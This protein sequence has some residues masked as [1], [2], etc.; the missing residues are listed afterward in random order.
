MWLPTRYRAPAV[1]YLVQHCD[2]RDA[3]TSQL[4]GFTAEREAEACLKQLT[5]EG[6]KDLHI[7]MVPVHRRLEDWEWDR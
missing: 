1:V 3:S 2:E 4:A 5:R 7:N 6:W